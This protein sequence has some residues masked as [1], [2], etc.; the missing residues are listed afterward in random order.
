M[1]APGLCRLG[2]LFQ[3]GLF[4]SDRPGFQREPFLFPACQAA[5]KRPH[6]RDTTPLQHQRHTG[7][8]GFVRS[9]TEE[10]QF[11]VNRYLIVPPVKFL[12]GQKQRAG[13]G[14]GVSL[15]IHRVPKVHNR[16]LFA[17]VDFQF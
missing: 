14:V 10:D 16:N 6:T 8:A 15:K 7:A 12:R 9:S 4:R 11:T 17:R 3:G 2:A 1:R 5:G 13:N